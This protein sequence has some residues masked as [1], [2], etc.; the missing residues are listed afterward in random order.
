GGLRRVL[1]A[2]GEAWVAGVDVDWTTVLTGRRVALPTYAFQR[3][4]YWLDAPVLPVQGAAGDPVESRFWD[5]V[6]REDLDELAGTLQLSEAPG[7]LGSVVPALASWRRERRQRSMVDTWRYRVTWSPLAG[8]PASVGLSGTWVVAG[9]VDDGV[10]AALSGAGASVVGLPVDALSQRD[11]LA[12]RITALGDVSGVVLVT[13]A[14]SVVSEELAGV[15]VLLRALG[16]AGSGAPLWVVTRG[17]VAVG[18]SDR[19][20][21]PVQ[22][23]VWGL[24]RVAALEYPQRWG[25]LVD[26]P[27]TIDARA[28]DR[29]AAVLAAGH[30][31]DQI[32]VR[33]SGLFGRRLVRA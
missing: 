23:A 30:G 16:D 15:V 2:L 21:D 28:G 14:A 12:E 9:R 3:Q 22:A 31:E 1:S 4:R 26:L 33:G 25:G 18:A 11:V 6:E 27:E 29:L 32:A 19:A 24:G 7:V 8:L 17:A 5:A 20:G 13:G 10:V